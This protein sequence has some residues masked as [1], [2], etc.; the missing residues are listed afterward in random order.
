MESP[1]KKA[2]RDE[3]AKLPGA[4]GDPDGDGQFPL[5]L[6]DVREFQRVVRDSCGV[7][8]DEVEAWNRATEIL[9]LY[10]MLLSPIPEDPDVSP[11]VRTSSDLEASRRSAVP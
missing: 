6:A 8:L 1:H 2:V 10:R 7:T 4:M 9:A 5:T 11:G 3:P